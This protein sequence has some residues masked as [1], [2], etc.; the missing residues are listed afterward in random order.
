MPRRSPDKIAPKT[1]RDKDSYV[2]TRNAACFV[3]LDPSE[4]DRLDEFWHSLQQE[5][6]LASISRPMALKIAAMR[7]LAGERRKL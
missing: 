4:S 5:P 1:S 3:R 2:H 7:Y 6:G